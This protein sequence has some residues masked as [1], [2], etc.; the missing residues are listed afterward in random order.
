MKTTN[1]MHLNH[2]VKELFNK[3][4]HRLNQSRLLT[5]MSVTAFANGELDRA[6]RFRNKA[7]RKSAWGKRY[8]DAGLLRFKCDEAEREAMEG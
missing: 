7:V 4:N 3:G 8:I 5:Q 1:Q 2:T 6:I